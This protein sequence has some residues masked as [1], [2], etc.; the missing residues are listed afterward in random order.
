MEDG[1]KVGYGFG[2]STE[3]FT[4]L[5]V[6]GL[7]GLLHYKFGLECG[8]H[9]SGPKHQAKLYVKAKS[10]DR[11][12]SLVAPHFQE[13]FL[14]KL[15]EGAHVAQN[16]DEVVLALHFPPSIINYKPSRSRGGGSQVAHLGYW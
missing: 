7:C 15:R 2:F 13:H 4:W 12:R 16:Q 10:M 1:G 14:Y 5:E 3:S 9:K 11:F 8:V 6:Y